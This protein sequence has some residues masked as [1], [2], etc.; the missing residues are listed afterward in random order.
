LLVKIQFGP[1]R[2]AQTLSNRM[3]TIGLVGGVA[4]G[5]SLVA[6]MLA[7]LGAG[8]LDADRAGHAVL[9]EDA[10]VQDALRQRWG[11]AV[12]AADGSI[13]RAAVAERVFAEGQAGEAEREFLE[14]LVHPRIGRRLEAAKERYAAEGKVAIVLDA[15]LLFEANWQPLCDLVVMVDAPRTAQLERARR[16]GWSE[17]DF[18]RRE[19]AQWP[20]QEKRSRADV[21]IRNDGSEQQ[22]RQMVRDFWQSHI[23]AP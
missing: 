22:L 14:A 19:A 1:L 5:K 13:D 17:T 11:D 2:T 10:D 21:V 18:S 15:A 4:S 12:F 3:K 8:V 7:Q 6:Q 23:A 9:A 16:R 20:V